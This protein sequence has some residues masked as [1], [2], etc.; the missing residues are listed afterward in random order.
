MMGIVKRRHALLVGLAAAGLAVSACSNGAASESR[1]WPTPSPVSAD[2]PVWADVTGQGV[3]APRD[4]TQYR[5]QYGS[6]PAPGIEIVHA[7]TQ[8]PGD[9]VPCT[10]GPAVSSGYLTAGHCAKGFS[11][12]QYLVGSPTGDLSL[13]GA[14]E[15]VNGP[16]DAAVIKTSR[17]PVTRIAGTWPVAGVLTQ[18]GVQKLVP[19]DSFV[20]FAGAVSGVRCGPRI[21]DRNGLVAFSGVSV[22][23]DS[24]APVFVVDPAIKRAAL[25]GILKGGN[26]TSSTATYL[27]SALLATGNAARLDPDTEAFDGAS[28]SQRIAG[29]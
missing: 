15:S 10:L 3:E 14:A 9:T 7:K 23:G 4:S 24:G 26:D 16:V 5:A 1:A 17:T 2:A 19:V 12:D 20:C 27:E 13:L 28:Y 21:A 22:E 11:P 8:T 25:V 6:T 18:A 29:K